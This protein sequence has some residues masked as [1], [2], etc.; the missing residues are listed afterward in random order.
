MLNAEQMEK[1][2]NAVGRVDLTKAIQDA[3]DMGI[4]VTKKRSGYHGMYNERGVLEEID[5]DKHFRMNSNSGIV[6][7]NKSSK[8]EI[9]TYTFIIEN[10]SKTSEIETDKLLLV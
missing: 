2:I 9:F 5:I 7:V 10:S 8:N 6:E 3:K 1:L 4:E